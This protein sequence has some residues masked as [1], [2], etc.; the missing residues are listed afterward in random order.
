MIE[1]SFRVEETP[2]GA[3]VTVKR[4][5]DA[6]FRLFVLPRIPMEFILYGADEE[7]PAELVI[8]FDRVIE[9]HFKLDVVWALVNVTVERLVENPSPGYADSY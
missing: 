9:H 6:A 4:K 8:T 5:D 1:F 3:D 2:P 7:F